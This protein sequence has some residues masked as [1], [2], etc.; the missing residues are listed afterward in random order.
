MEKKICIKC[1]DPKD[2]NEYY[3]VSRNANKRRNICKSCHSLSMKKSH[4]NNKERR[5]EMSKIWCE[6]NKDKRRES[7]IRNYDRERSG[8]HT[9]KWLD[10]NPDYKKEYREKNKDCLSIKNK[11]YRE[12]NK[13][14]INN[15]SRLWYKNNKESVYRRVLEYRKK[16]NYIKVKKQTDP[17]FRLKINIRNNIRT[18]LIRKKQRKNSRTYIILGCTFEFFKNHI[19]SKFESWMTWENYGLYNGHNNYGWDLDHIVPLSSADT[20]DKVISLNHY[21]NF[22]PLC[23]FVNRALKRGLVNWTPSNE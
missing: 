14:E 13:L 17:L 20:E 10:K 18:A 16:T 5:R 7:R 1:N 9:K 23:S 11:E 4:D 22:Q 21:T 12:K 3:L 2:L 15:R 8:N 19:E 6:N